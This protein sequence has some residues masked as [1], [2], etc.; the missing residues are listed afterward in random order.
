MA[1]H[2]IEQKKN[3][4]MLVIIIISALSIS[5]TATR[6]PAFAPAGC[7]RAQSREATRA[8]VAFA[9]WAATARVQLL[10][11]CL[12]NAT[13]TRFAAQEASKTRLRPRRWHCGLCGKEFFEEA[14]LDAHLHGR[15]GGGDAALPCLAERCHMLGCPSFEGGGDGGGDGA[16]AAVLRSCVPAPEG[17]FLRE[18]HA[19]MCEAPFAARAAARRATDAAAEGFQWTLQRALLGALAVACVAWG[20]REA[21]RADLRDPI[22]PRRVR[23]ERVAA[24]AAAAAAAAP[25]GAPPAAAP[26]G[27]KR[28]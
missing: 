11:G 10:P 26:R 22:V 18:A 6:P 4:S 19:S 16:C 15:H 27:G 23:L 20:L 21:Y 2:S 25:V 12:L 8:A 13:A 5:S 28:D 24:A 3:N 14:W 1:F 17:A 7:S 9:A